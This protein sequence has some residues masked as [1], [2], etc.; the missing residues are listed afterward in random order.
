M[1]FTSSHIYCKIFLLFCGLPVHSLNSGFPVLNLTVLF[2][3]TIMN[4]FP[5]VHN[6]L[7]V[8]LKKFLH[9]LR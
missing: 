3:R 5:L 6:S 1:T 4:H 7:P 8:L 2:I 9:I